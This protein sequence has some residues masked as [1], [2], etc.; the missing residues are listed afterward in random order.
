M[1]D[2]Q[3]ILNSVYDSSRNALRVSV[4]DEAIFVPPMN[5]SIMLAA[6][7]EVQGTAGSP[8]RGPLAA[9]TDNGAGAF[10]V[11]P[12]SWVTIAMDVYWSKS[13]TGG[14]GTN[15]RWECRYQRYDSGDLK[16]LAGRTSHAGL[17]VA[18][19]ADNTIAATELAT[20]IAITPG[21]PYFIG[22][23]RLGLHAADDISV[24]CDLHGLRFR[25]VT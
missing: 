21:A 3:G 24:A 4:A 25:R 12:S 11:F 16:A 1:P 18:P 17:T 7:A 15:V 10:L 13:A 5:M 22:A 20:G 14:T 2:A 6:S 19:P 9:A 8:L 23:I